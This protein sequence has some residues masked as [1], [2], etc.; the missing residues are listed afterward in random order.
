[1]K[2]LNVK[3][4]MIVVLFV[5][6]MYIGPAMVLGQDEY[7]D[8]GEDDPEA[9]A[10][11]YRNFLGGFGNM[12][13][14]LG[15]GGNI[16]GKVFQTMFM[17][18]LSLQKQETLDNVF[19]LSANDTETDNG[20]IDYGDGKSDRFYL[21]Q[22]ESYN[23]TG[24]EDPYCQVTREGKVD[25]T[26]TQGAGITL[27]IWD[28]D[29]SFINAAMKVI[30]LIKRVREAEE[31]NESNSEDLI[32]EAASTISWFLIHINDIFTGDELFVL[33]PI[34][35]QNLELDPYDDFNVNRTWYDGNGSLIEEYDED[36][37]AQWNDTANETKDSRMQ[38]LLNPDYNDEEI[39]ETRWT[40]FSFDLIQLW[41]KNFE[42]HIDVSAFLDGEDMNP[43]DAFSGCDIEFFLFSHHLSGAFLYNDLD[44]DGVVSVDEYIDVEY[45]D[46]EGENK[47]GQIPTTNELT[48]K[49]ILGGVNQF[50]FQQPEINQDENSISWGLTL[51]Q[52]NITAVPVGVDLASYMSTE[53]DELDFIYFG[54]KFEPKTG[55][56]VTAN[57]GTEI[58]AAKGDVKLE[59]NFAPWNKGDGP[60]QN[61]DGLDM[62]ILYTS[63]VLHFH[64]NVENTAAD[65]E[66]PEALLS[67]ES[68]NNEEQKLQLGNYLSDE[69]EA[70]LDFVDIAGPGYKMG[71]N[72]TDDN[73]PG[74]DATDFEAKTN[75]VPVAL[76]TSEQESRQIYTGDN[77]TTSDDFASD[78]RVSAEFQVLLY[79]VCYP[80]FNG[81]GM[82]IWHDPTF[83]VYMVF[84]ATGFWALI[85]L[86]AGIGLVGV[87]TIFIKKRKDA[88]I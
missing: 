40:Q 83:S 12:F 7:D 32:E 80:D 47:T 13:S 4:L 44:G 22:N 75:T 1:M 76:W 9:D 8:D 27:I 25:Y 11:M 64:L 29:K 45:E 35:W 30:D 38:W 17:E 46:Q 6:T 78:V 70:N 57:D 73:T 54:Y 2:K 69:V 43:A 50:R 79:A 59:H 77:E 67:Q 28:D 58:Q 63:T 41:V 65:P 85:L 84:E 3:G 16:I 5:S 14:T 86:V 49:L 87:A 21:P 31:N 62:A 26:L 18:G 81:T 68:Y 37:L 55:D 15:Y 39:V 36:Y 52:V 82:G 72:Q 20:T 88:R 60:N 19:V 51:D 61:I 48:H 71:Y 23:T 42:I 34:T 33:N 53:S 56:V 24:V 10:A 66:D 74:E